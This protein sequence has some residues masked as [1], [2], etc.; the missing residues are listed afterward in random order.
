MKKG[1]LV[2]FEYLTHHPSGVGWKLHKEVGLIIDR[3]TNNDSF[4]IMLKDG[5][6]IERLDIHV[7]LIS[8]TEK[9]DI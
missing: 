8:S 2:W 4:I 6:I 1:D 3:D 7:D 5:K 9:Q